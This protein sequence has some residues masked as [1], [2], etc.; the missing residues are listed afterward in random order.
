MNPP[1]PTT[2]PTDFGAG[3]L[4]HTSV[5]PASLA[6][7]AI[8]PLTVSFVNM[9]PIPLDGRIEVTLPTGFYLS[10]DQGAEPVT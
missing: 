8:S 7:G 3:T 5:S 2:G 1:P 10:A 4:G 9:N 6:A